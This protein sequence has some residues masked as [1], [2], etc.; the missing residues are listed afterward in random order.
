ME[1][2]NGQVLDHYHGYILDM[3]GG[4]RYEQGCESPA[5]VIVRRLYRP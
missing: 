5:D 3:A 1:V 4:G 2:E